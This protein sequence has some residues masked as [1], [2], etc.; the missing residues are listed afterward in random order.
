MNTGEAILKAADD[1]LGFKTR[2]NKKWFRT[3]N[4]N[5][6]GLIDIRK[7]ARKIYLQCQNMEHC[8][9][10]KKL[11]P[12]SGYS[13]GKHI[14]KIGKELVKS[15]EHDITGPQRTDITAFKNLKAIE[16]DQFRMS[17]MPND[18]WGALQIIIE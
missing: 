6:K 12:E 1:S 11:R 17:L 5:L 16:N 18:G 9:E 15:L 13:Q 3:W 7:K 14:G 2:K 10:Y 8:V 4:V